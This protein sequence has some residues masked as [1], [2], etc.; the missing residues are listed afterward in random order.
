MPDVSSIAQKLVLWQTNFFDKVMDMALWV[1][2]RPTLS[3]RV[4]AG[5]IPANAT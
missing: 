3:K 5:L 4:Y 2:D 1:S